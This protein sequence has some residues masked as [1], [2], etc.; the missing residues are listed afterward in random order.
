MCRIPAYEAFL[1]E[2]NL[3]PANDIRLTEA[4]FAVPAVVWAA[5]ELD[6]K[7]A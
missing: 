3:G 5:Q 4:F 1:R 7:I 6:S 2:G